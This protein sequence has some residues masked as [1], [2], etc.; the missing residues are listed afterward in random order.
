MR[1][2]I[3][4]EYAGIDALRVGEMPEPEPFPGTAIVSVRAA[5]VNFAD[6]LVVAGQYQVK[7][8]LPFVPGGELAGVVVSADGLD[9]F[10]PGDRVCGFTGFGAMAERAVAYPGS[11]TRLPDH[12]SF[13]TGAA[14]PVAYG[15]SY[16]ALVD[17]ARLEADETL[18]VLGAAGGVGIA[19]VQIGKAL[20]AIVVAA[21][22]SEEKATAARE[23]GADEIVRYDQVQLRDGIAAATGGAGV[24]VVYDP[25]GG[26]ATELALRSTK[27]NG[28]LLVIGFASGEIPSLPLNL[29]LV[30]GNSVVGVF[31][32]RFNM[33]EPELSAANNRVIMEWVANGT[34]RPLVQKTYPLD[35]SIEALRW[36]ADRK[37]IGRVV[38]TP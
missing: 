4:D 26:P 27:W 8:D 31:W 1:A 5:A 10:A 38:V 28:R 7:P 17:R 9:G 16:H 30:K 21:V 25:V 20:G 37:A 13:E 2:L 19:A 23:A 34:L 35:E 14:I 15:T 24:D 11:I 22:S 36:V 12:V 33:E 29:N 3:C 32:G 18:L 6:V